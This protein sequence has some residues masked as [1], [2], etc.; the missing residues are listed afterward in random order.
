MELYTYD[1]FLRKVK[2]DGLLNEHKMWISACQAASYMEK[3]KSGT[4]TKKEYWKFMRQQHELFYGSHYNEEF[5]LWDVSQMTYTSKAGEK[6]IGGEYWTKAQIE[7]ATKNM[8]FPANVTCWDK[9]VAFNSFHADL[10]NV[11]DDETII[12]AAYKYFFYDEDAPEGKVW[13]YVNCMMN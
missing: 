8:S 2:E 9:Y 6:R 12:K 3:A 7:E 10:C 13:K 1:A 4:L 5:A 11:L